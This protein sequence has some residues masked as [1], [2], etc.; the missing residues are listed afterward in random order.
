MDN[1]AYTE[2]EIERCTLRGQRDI[3]F[4]LRGLI[5]RNE[6][7]SVGFQEGRQSFLTVLI[8]ISEEN[9][10]LYFDIG[11]SEETNRAFLKAEHSTFVANC[12][13][14]RLQ[15][16][17]GQAREARL[18]GDTVFAI[19]LPKSL[20]RLQRREFF[21]LELPSAKPYLCRIRRGSAQEKALALHDISVGG[22]GIFSQEAIHFE[23]ME[24]LENCWIDLRDTGVL[25]VTLE[26][27]YAVSLETRSGKPL[28]HIGCRFVNLSSLNE[29]LIQRFMS[30]LQ[31]ERKAL[32]K[33]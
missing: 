23:Q 12:D 29:T 32:L 28:W 21:R 20:L 25:A 33:E 26:V 18:R 10:A 4:Q 3:S 27:R 9:N 22:I 7:V 8:D 30:R 6:R 1:N 17:A 31:A 16:S 15:F 13:G 2:E 19:A 11:G 14:I 5:K 24:I